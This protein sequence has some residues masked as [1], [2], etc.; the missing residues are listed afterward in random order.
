MR[1]D[2]IG[3][4]IFAKPVSFYTIYARNGVKRSN[5]YPKRKQSIEAK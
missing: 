3:K 2:R 1:Y 5:I 4:N